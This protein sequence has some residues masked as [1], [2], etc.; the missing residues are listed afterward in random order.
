MHFGGGDISNS[1]HQLTTFPY[2]LFC[3][4]LQDHIKNPLLKYIDA[5]E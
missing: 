1:H 2:F 3:D 4:Y 5:Y